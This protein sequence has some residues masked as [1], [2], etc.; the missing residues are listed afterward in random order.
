VAVLRRE[1]MALQPGVIEI[2]GIGSGWKN[3]GSAPAP[4]RA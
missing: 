2:N 4:L 1:T 3:H